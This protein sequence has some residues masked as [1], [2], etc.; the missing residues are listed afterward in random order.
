MIR[1]SN[2]RHNKS[3][4]IHNVQLKVAVNYKQILAENNT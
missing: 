2:K 4:K 3:F 1:Q